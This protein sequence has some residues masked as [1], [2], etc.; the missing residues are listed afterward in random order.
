MKKNLSLALII[1]ASLSA[2]NQTSE[3]AQNEQ[4]VAETAADVNKSE[5]VLAYEAANTKMHT[6]MLAVNS[7]PDIAFMQ[8]MIPH[9]EGAVEMAQ[10]VLKYGKDPETRALAQEVIEAQTKE[11]TQMTAWLKKHNAEPSTVS[12]VDHAAMG[13]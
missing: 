9:H 6:A 4:K 3:G 11:I 10:V 2:C 12:D 8:G 1:L 5:A 7:D 13:H